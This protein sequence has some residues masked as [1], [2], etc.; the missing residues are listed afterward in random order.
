MS[1]SL[2]SLQALILGAI[3]ALAIGVGGY[4]LWALDQRRGLGNDPLTVEVGFRDIGGVEVGTRIR[5]QGIDAGE[6]EAAAARRLPTAPSW[7]PMSAPSCSTPSPRPRPSSTRSC[8][9]P[10]RPSRP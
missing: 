8:T 7:R 3:V 2:T 9:R 1:R 10:R 5:V 4:T 6:V